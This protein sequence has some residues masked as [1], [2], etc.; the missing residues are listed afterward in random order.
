MKVLLINPPRLNEI[1]ADNPAFI[2][3]ERGFNPPL[4]LL[5]LAGYLKNKSRHQVF[6]LD[7]QVEGL[8]YGG[9]FEKRISAINPDVVGITAMTFTLV[10]V[11]K[12][13]EI[14]RAAE[15][16]NNKKI[17]IVLGGPHVHLFPKETAGL[18]EVDFTVKGEGE[19][20]FF[21]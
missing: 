10:D 9:E 1:L 20:P 11:L 19:I 8:D 12:T 3:E 2:E 5:Y 6:V 4:G 16:K 7:A 17:L 21:S 14:V 18:K 13:I 15:K